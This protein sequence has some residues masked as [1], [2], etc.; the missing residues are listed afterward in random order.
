MR[1]TELAWVLA[2]GLVGC[3]D[4]IVV[5]TDSGPTEGTDSGARDA[6]LDGATVHE[7]GA[8]NGHDGAGPGA[9]VPAPDTVALDASLADGPDR[10]IGSAGLPWCL[11]VVALGSPPPDAPQCNGLLFYQLGFSPDYAAIRR[12][13]FGPDGNLWIPH[14]KQ[15]VPDYDAGTLW[16]RD[17]TLEVISTAGQMVKSFWLE[18]RLQGASQLALGRDGNMWLSASIYARLEKLTPDG[19][20]TELTAENSTVSGA[21]AVVAGQDGNIWYLG[22]R[23][24]G[25]P[26]IGRVTPAEANEETIKEFPIQVTDYFEG[27]AAA[28]GGGVWFSASRG[29]GSDAALSTD[30]SFYSMTADGEVTRIAT[31]TRHFHGGAIT[32]GPDGNLWFIHDFENLIGRV[33]MDGTVTTFPLLSPRCTQASAGLYDITA[34]ADGNLWY[35]NHACKT[36]GR[37]TPSGTMTELY[38]NFFPLFITSGPD[39]NLWFTSS[40]GIGR[41]IP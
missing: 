31:T 40:H 9:E 18:G 19:Q 3:G 36:V 39:G 13:A 33:E 37:I 35:T 4:A 14:G 16:E 1:K 17:W 15:L 23:Y 24:P 41:I 20:L 5:P 12:L 8:V 30:I 32:A 6:A 11:D 34:G 2:F 26:V 7:V 38:L 25:N 22:G 21:S 27:F 28:P 29:N 10:E